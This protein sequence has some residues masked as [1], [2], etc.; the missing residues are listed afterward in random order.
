MTDTTIA[1]ATSSPSPLSEYGGGGCSGS[2]R[3]YAEADFL[4]ATNKIQSSI[5]D[6]VQRNGAVILRWKAAR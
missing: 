5:Q 6:S 2:L 3:K 4:K 1:P